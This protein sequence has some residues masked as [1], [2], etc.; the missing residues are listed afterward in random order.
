MSMR[1]EILNQRLRYVD[2]H[3]SVNYVELVLTANTFNDLMNRM[4]CAQQVAASDRKLLGELGQERSRFDQTNADLAVQR[5]HV[6]AL[7]QQEAATRAALPKP[8]P[9]PNA[10]TPP[11]HHPTA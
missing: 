10:P 7:L 6:A 8:L 1:D 2:D 9:P 3:G 5:G 11:A 4:V